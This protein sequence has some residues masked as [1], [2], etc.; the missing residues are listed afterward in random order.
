MG[1]QWLIVMRLPLVSIKL[2]SSTIPFFSVHFVQFG[3]LILLKKPLHMEEGFGNT[4]VIYAYCFCSLRAIHSTVES[5]SASN[6]DIL[7]LKTSLH[8]DGFCIIY[9]WHHS[10]N[11]CKCSEGRPKSPI[12]TKCLAQWKFVLA[13]LY[14]SQWRYKNIK[15]TNTHKKHIGDLAFKF[16]INTTKLLSISLSPKARHDNAPVKIL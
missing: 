10:E 9:L 14:L 11:I 6:N 4:V 8:S 2:V 16:V 1:L 7:K 5:K 15:A 3:S 13:S 12:E